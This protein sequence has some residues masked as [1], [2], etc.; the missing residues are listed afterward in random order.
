MNYEFF[1]FVESRI[2]SHEVVARHFDCPSNHFVWRRARL[3][4]LA[5]GQSSMEKHLKALLTATRSVKLKGIVD[6]HGLLAEM[7]A[8]PGD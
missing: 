5:K 6:F 7:P 3:R 1:K 2:P 4:K 8:Y